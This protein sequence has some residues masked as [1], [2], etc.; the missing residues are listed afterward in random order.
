[1]SEKSKMILVV[2]IP[3]IIFIVLVAAAVIGGMKV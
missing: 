3:T 2:T 1:M